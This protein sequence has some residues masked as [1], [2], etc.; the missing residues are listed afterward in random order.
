MV[1][2]SVCIAE[3]IQVRW[4][5]K[6]FC[7]CHLVHDVEVLPRNSRKLTDPVRSNSS[8]WH[9]KN[10]TETKTWIQCSSGGTKCHH[11]LCFRGCCLLCLESILCEM[12]SLGNLCL[13]TDGSGSSLRGRPGRGRLGA[14]LMF[15]EI[16]E[17]PYCST[18]AWKEGGDRWGSVSSS[19]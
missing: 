8:L 3:L 9:W 6:F 1:Q 16:Q 5:A 15:Q 13:C 4:R 10:V 2:L 17:G 19:R 12:P 14:G 11:F 18:A 7:F